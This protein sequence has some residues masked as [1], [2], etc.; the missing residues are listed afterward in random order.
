MKI[1]NFR[2]DKLELRSEEGLEL[3]E[4]LALLSQFNLIPN[5]SRET[6]TAKPEPVELELDL[7]TL[8]KQLANGNWLILCSECNKAKEIRFKPKYGSA[9]CDTCYQLDKVGF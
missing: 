3:A 8:P 1:N 5:V 2:F 9:K 6:V 7:S 4:M